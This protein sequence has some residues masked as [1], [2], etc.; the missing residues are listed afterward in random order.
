MLKSYLE[1][2]TEVL[3]RGDATEPSF[4][5]I[6]E[7]LLKDFSDSSGRKNVHIT[8]LPKKTEAGNPDF[9]VW[10][11]N[12]RIT[13]YIEAKAPSIMPQGIAS[14]NN[15][16]T[17]ERS[18]QLQ[19]YRDTFPNMILTNFF[20]FR[21]YRNGEFIGGVS[22]GR[23]VIAHKLK[24]VP[25]VENEAR[26][27]ELFEK[28]FSFSLPEV[29]NAETLAVELAKRTR[30]LRD[31]VIIVELEERI[32]RGG[33]SI[34]G[35]YEA[36]KEYLIADLKK[37]S[38]ADLY[39]QTITYGLFAARMRSQDGFNRESAFGK[40]P[41]TIGILR[42][43]FR[44]ISLGD[45]PP[46]M[47]WIVDDI[48]EIL[49]VTDVKK[50]LDQY[51][52]EGK[53]ADPV[54]HFYETFLA[55]YDPKAREIRGVYYTPEP[56]VSYIVRSVHL[57]LMD[58]FGKPDGLA[59]KSV[60]VLDPAAGTLTFLAEAAKL[61]VT[62]HTSRW[63]DGDLPQ[64]IN[65][66]VVAHFFALELMMAP[67]AI[68][69]IK[70]SFLLEE[71]GYV[72]KD[73][74]RI[75]LFLTNTL[76]MEELKE[77][78]LPGMSS[79][80]HESHS[81]AEV[82]SLK[83]ILAIIGN[84]PYSG[85]SSNIGRWISD[86]IKVYHKIDGAPLKEKNPKWLQDDYVKFIRF[87]QWKIDRMGEG[88]LGFITNHGYLDNPTFRGMR[89]SLMDSFDEI[90]ILDLHGNSLKKEK[91][92][93][94]AKDENVF[95]IRQGVAIALFVKKKGLKKKVFHAD[96]Y[97]ERK[98][99]YSWL[100]D[101]DVNTIK[102]NRI[103]PKSDFYLFIQRD[104]R[105]LAGY[106][107]FAKV[108]EIFPVNSVGVVTS[109]DEFVIDFDRD[110][111]KR[112][113]IEFRNMRQPDEI[114]TQTY[115]LKNKNGWHVR[116]ARQ[117][118]I[119]DNDWENHIIKILYRPFDERWIFFHDAVIERSRKEVM[120]H[121]VS[122]EILALLT[123]R[124]EELDIPYAHF[125][126]TALISEHGC[127]STKTTN[128]H[129]PLYT[130]PSSD[131]KDL[132]HHKNMNR[133]PNINTN[134]FNSLSKDYN[135]APSPE[136]IFHYIYAVLYSETYRARYAEFLKMDF[137]RVPFTGDY[138]L[139]CKM[140]ALGK[141]LTDLHLLKSLALDTPVAKFQGQG[142]GRV[143][144]PKYDEAAECV[145]I[146]A[147]Q[148]F[149]GVSP[150]LWNYQIG[151]YQVLNKWLKDRKDRVLTL[152]EAQTYSKIVTA[153]QKT[154]EIQQEI[155][156][157]YDEVEINPIEFASPSKIRLEI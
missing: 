41:K 97:G 44:F 116:D 19:R 23:P 93:D 126:A 110:K 144:K 139:F 152:D 16:E 18:E 37:D 14:P 17:I 120:Q 3:N 54:V 49:S 130:Y 6:L 15:L 27:M 21:L 11:G 101:N 109:R 51:Y 104:E 108:T 59:D 80:S 74:E 85:H 121:M 47:V 34:R 115:N 94:G 73:D 67:Y 22:I 99:K 100:K 141:R 29:L 13:G 118:V 95:D 8:T 153:I 111:L 39:A 4:Y 82:K 88:V 113:I 69:H 50:I 35:Y 38:F 83:P 60:T 119:K 52:H 76:D 114:I 122:G 112:R 10:D 155:D 103:K 57:I 128:Y 154:I 138:G 61:A 84:P 89:R 149:Q 78:R 71:L 131:K 91:C 32:Q 156:A 145:Y 134:I 58:K 43:I 25:P 31:E 146:N 30:F 106:E 96:L 105:R 143:G 72:L 129:F 68:G 148:Y 87:A 9:R 102:W 66:H 123:H 151:G 135:A 64:F 75:N 137:P 5:G 56:V 62:E 48:S 7:D 63:G 125:L 33:E 90:Y 65:E 136:A 132:F 46:Q 79:L 107:K 150:K 28:F 2:I 157:L 142:D 86:E 42:D 55:Q 92:P 140:G 77:S 24:T 147:E 81:A 1:K 20:E 45:L 40:I 70:M 12:S 127:L 36:F 124:R 98:W 53:G 133:K 117:A 26:F